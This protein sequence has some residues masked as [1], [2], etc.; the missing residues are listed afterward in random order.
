MAEAGTATKSNSAYIPAFDGIR[1]L[2][3]FS[4][5]IIHLHF[6]LLQIPNTLGYFTMHC[7]FIMSSYLITRGLM[8]DKKNHE[9]FGSY[10][11]FFYIK[12]SLRILPVY[13]AYLLLCVVVASV[14]YKTDLKKVLGLVYEFKYFGWMLLTFT[15]NLKDFLCLFTG[16]ND[17]ASP[18]TPHLWSL[19]LEE[20]FYFTIPFIIYFCSIKTLK[21]ITIA[22]ILIFPVFRAIGYY[23]L[24]DHPNI[25]LQAF[26]ETFVAFILY[27]STFFQFDAFFYG[28]FVVL[29]DF[30][31]K[32]LIKTAFYIILSLLLA[33]I[34]YNGFV[35][36]EK[37]GKPFMEVVSHYSFMIK[38]GQFLY[39]DFLVN[40]LCVLL[41]YLCF[42]LDDGFGIFKNKFFVF[43]G[44]ISYGVY[45][46]Q[47]IF[48]FPAVMLL[49]P[50]LVSS[51][52]V[53][54]GEALSL[55]IS[56]SPL[57]LLSNLSYQKMEL[58]FIQLKDRFIPKKSRHA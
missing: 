44:K 35:I 8:H 7:F 40:A 12:R 33:S 17:F 5:L 18:V 32:Q 29:F 16:W 2:F 15:Y 36:S 21:R 47:Y 39:L 24:I 45:V 22:A 52:G 27:R 42:K 1:G 10:F 49:T 4:I 53:F 54:F 56:L 31:N 48:I 25:E 46:Y 3:S 30:Q 28:I 37:E 38:N 26:P 58:Y 6:S 55:L 34:V 57:L 13:I 14:T 23:Y 43:V 20:Q 11:K 9:Q 51:L 41:F 50:F 19:S